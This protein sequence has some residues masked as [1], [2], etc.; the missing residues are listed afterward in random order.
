M[1]SPINKTYFEWIPSDGNI[2]ESD[3]HKMRF[4]GLWDESYV[5]KT[6]SACSDLENT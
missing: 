6:A 4:S 2:I 5:I 3:I 1:K